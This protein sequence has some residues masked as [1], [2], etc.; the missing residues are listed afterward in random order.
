ME[1]KIE[2]EVCGREIK[3]RYVRAN[4]GRNLKPTNRRD[5][6][7]SMEC[8]E[9]YIGKQPHPEDTFRYRSR[10]TGYYQDAAGRNKNKFRELKNMQRYR[11]KPKMHMNIKKA[12]REYNAILSDTVDEE[13]IKVL[14]KLS[15]PMYDHDISSAMGVKTVMVRKLLNELHGY[16]FAEYERTKDKKTGWYTYVWNR[17][18][19]KVREHIKNYIERDLRNLEDKLQEEEENVMFTCECKVNGDNKH[20]TLGQAM[21]YEFVCPVCNA[22]LKEFDNSGFIS[23]LKSDISKVNEKLKKITR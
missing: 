15:R 22:P 7:C 8:T 1:Q 20:V 21:E 2:C 17:R 9:G 13:H 14:K 4:T 23:K 19:D 3:G 12:L 16:G 5:A 6:A 10:I 18:D 11:I